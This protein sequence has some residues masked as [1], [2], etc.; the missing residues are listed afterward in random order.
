MSTEGPFFGRRQCYSYWACRGAES[1]L[2]IFPSLRGSGGVGKKNPEKVLRK[3]EKTNTNRKYKNTSFSRVPLGP[4]PSG[5]KGR[6][7]GGRCNLRFAISCLLFLFSTS[8]FSF[9]FSFFPPE[10][11]GNGALPAVSTRQPRNGGKRLVKGLV[12][13]V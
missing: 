5:P 1:W 13:N 3:K 7:S 6:P 10:G 9:L 2:I 12:F 11:R 4:F 8:T